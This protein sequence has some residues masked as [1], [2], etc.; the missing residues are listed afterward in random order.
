[1]C[2][3]KKSGMSNYILAKYL[4]LTNDTHEVEQSADKHTSH[5][6][7]ENSNDST[8]KFKR[9][10]T[11]QQNHITRRRKRLNSDETLVPPPAKKK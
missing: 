9:N 11:K 5:D 6:D 8:H 7:I 4:K 2:P 3:F 10:E 1:M